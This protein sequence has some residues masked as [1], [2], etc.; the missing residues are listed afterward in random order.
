MKK[1][2]YL[3]LIIPAL[4]FGQG[5]I[6][7]MCGTPSGIPP[8]GFAKNRDIM[9]DT[10][11]GINYKY[12]TTW[13]I[14][15]G[16][17]KALA[18]KDGVN[19]KDGAQGIQGIPGTPGKDGVCPSCPPSGGMAFPF[20]IVI[21][22]GNDDA[23]VNAA[24]AENNTTSKTIYFQGNVSTGQINIPFNSF[25]L[26]MFGWG[27]KW[28]MKPGTS[29]LLKRAQPVDNTQ[30]LYMTEA[31]FFIQGFEFIGNNVATCIEPGPSY[32]SE[33]SNNYFNGWGTGIY[34]R[35]ALNCM[36]R[37]NHFYCLTG[38][39]ADMGN[40][41]NATNSNSQSNN[42][43][44]YNNRYRILQGSLIASAAYAASGNEW[45]SNIFE[46]SGANKVIYFDFKMSTVVKD[47]TIESAHIETLNGNGGGTTGNAY[48]Y[49]R[50]VGTAHI[51]R[52]FSQYP[53]CLINAS[54]EP[55]QLQ[56]NISEINWCV[57]PQDGKL[58]YNGGGTRWNFVDNTTDVIN[59]PATLSSKF[60]GT[61]VTECMGTG[62]GNNKWTLK[63]FDYSSFTRFGSARIE[64]EPVKPYKLTLVVKLE[65]LQAMHPQLQ[66]LALGVHEWYFNTHAEAQIFA[67]AN[68]DFNSLI[69]KQ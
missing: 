64:T 43:F 56:L 60:A 26:T 61:A 33:F 4:S 5:R 39:V 58:F 6:W 51:S 67:D 62:C 8:T 36:I 46:W 52:I 45:V 3:L 19:G 23:A 29:T 50:G 27:C 54:G 17:K 40:W 11:A 2:L 49:I 7:Q 18:G 9:A 32:M 57:M 34:N 41:P 12:N 16:I 24:I 48:I 10:C 63:N 35:F 20:I 68:P 28:T 25:R 59:N 44:R 38:D 53:G 21:G 15:N 55:A 42:V 1:L 22:T 37:M 13:I 47:L 14:N 31:R 66:P 30:A 65:A 69:E